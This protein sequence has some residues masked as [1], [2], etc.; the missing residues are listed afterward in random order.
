MIL[1]ESWF[2]KSLCSA[3]LCSALLCSALLCCLYCCMLCRAYIAGVFIH[4]A[5][6]CWKG[7]GMGYGRAEK[8]GGKRGS[9]LLDLYSRN[10]SLLWVKL[11]ELEE[12]Y[13]FLFK[14][15]IEEM[16]FELYIEDMCFELYIEENLMHYFHKVP[17]IGTSWKS[18]FV[19]FRTSL[20]S[21]YLQNIPG[22]TCSLANLNCSTVMGDQC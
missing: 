7:R 15:Y 11:G 8:L 22:H 2:W 17:P 10:H 6:P 9:A 18:I 3:L 16:D 13:C 4:Q 1:I 20:V 21:S 19:T 12:I 5:A 14:L